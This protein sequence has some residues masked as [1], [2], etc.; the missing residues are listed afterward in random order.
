MKSSLVS[1]FKLTD[2][3]LGV[4]L[5]GDLKEEVSGDLQEA[6]L[7]RT[8][9]KGPGYAKAFLIWEL[10]VSLR[11]T[12]RTFIKLKIGQFMFFQNFIKTGF[13]FLWKTRRYSFIN[14]LGL[15][16]GITLAGYTWLFVSDQYSYDRFHT[17]AEDTYRIGM[18]M[19]YKGETRSFGGASFVM[20]EEFKKQISG[21][22]AASQVK[23]GYPL[24]KHKGETQDF[25][26]H[27]V[28]ADIFRILDFEFLS[29]DASLFGAPRDVFVSR[30]FFNRMEQ[31]ETI[32]FIF[33]GEIQLFQVVAIY[34]D[35]PRNSSLRPE[36]MV[37]NSFF[38][39]NTPEGRLTH[40][41]N[42]NMNVLVRLDAGSSQE[43][44]EQQMTAL[45]PEEEEEM[46]SEIFLQPLTEIHT[47]VD[48]NAGNGLIGTMDNAVLLVLILTSLLCLLISTLNFANF[49]IGNYL[50]R[51]KEVGIRKA[52]GADRTIIFSQFLIEVSLNVLLAVLLAWVLQILLLSS[53]S[54]YI[55]HQYGLSALFTSKYLIG[56]VSVAVL[57]ILLSG[58]FP[59]LFLSSMNVL[60]A[61]RGY[62]FMAH[63]RP[64]SKLFLSFQAA[65]SIF[66]LLVTITTQQQLQYL[67]DFD[68]GYDSENLFFGQLQNHEKSEIL[69]E[70]LL[71]LPGIEYISFNSGYNGT[72]L[73]GDFDQISTRI[74]HVDPDFV[75][76]M[77]LEIVQGRNLNPEISTDQ[78]SAALITETMAR[79]LGFEHPV[80]QELPIHYGDLKDP[81]IVG[82]VKD[83]HFQSPRYDQEPLVMSLADS[84]PF[85]YFFVKSTQPDLTITDKVKEVY[86]RLYAPYGLEFSLVSEFNQRVHDSE[87][88]VSRVSL[89]GSCLAIFLA[90]LGLL[91]VLGTNIEKRMKEVTIHKING[92][93]VRALYNIFFRN[94]L[95]WLALGLLGGL[96]PAFYLI[97]G[98]LEG[99]ANRITLSADIFIIGVVCCSVI[100]LIVMLIQLSRINRLNPVNFLK[101][102]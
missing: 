89:M 40:W 101:D 30:S 7:I 52:I 10:L 25:V 99:Y 100:F 47:N 39:S 11:L 50:K 82:V 16:L 54:T 19:T 29:G 75:E 68:L 63:R 9:K 83:F 73:T 77:D 78:T 20:G 2:R 12:N 91:G 79:E 55:E 49:S 90:A 59:A 102:E 28:D 81:K 86:E 84:Y 34:E 53:F 95:P 22:K 38:Q 60:Q 35:I 51:V 57:A 87:A 61:L 4:F 21:I 69:K 48:L 24:L 94:F 37:A 45:L 58:V 71:K 67:L 17:H 8:S 42:I 33:D 15:T 65:L 5:Q 96:L 43:I 80:G 6:Y 26:C 98:W 41:F 72:R 56:M 66:M 23:S 62:K 92:A 74:L 97:D 76:M 27:Y 13:R 64:M 85:Q 31:P 1:D 88:K 93:S 32:E 70:E 46:I 36:V 44:I 14:I 18:N 3:L